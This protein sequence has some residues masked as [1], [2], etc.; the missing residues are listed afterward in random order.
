MIDMY[1][2][3]LNAATEHRHIF[4]FRI[5]SHQWNAEFAF[6]AMANQSI[7]LTLKKR[8]AMHSVW[9]KYNIISG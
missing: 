8:K 1:T 7:F 5:N 2:Y 9:F 6:N 4:C 3:L